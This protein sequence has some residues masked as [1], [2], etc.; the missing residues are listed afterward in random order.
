MRIDDIPLVSGGSPFGHLDELKRDRFALF[1]RLGRECGDIGAISAFGFPL[2][3]ANAPPLVHEVLVEKAKSFIK[4]PG[5]VGPLRPLAGEGLFTSEGELW[6]RQR[7]LMSPLFQHAQI[8]RYA[9][10]MVD[11]ARA[12]VLPLREGQVFD[13]ARETT[14]IA[15]RVAG[16][17]LFG[18]D[19]LD[20]ADELGAALT[21]ALHWIN[22]KSASPLLV[23]QIRLSELVTELGKHLPEPLQRRA[24]ELAQDMVVPLRLPGEET[25][26]LEHA[27][28][29]VDGQVER[30]IAERRAGGVAGQQDL[31]ARLLSVHDE[32]GERMSD[33]QL[34]DEIVTLFIAGHETTAT[35]L[36]WS[37]YLLSRHPEAYQRAKAEAEALGGRRARF[38]DLPRLSYCLQVFKEAMRLYPPIYIFGRKAIA[39]VEIGGYELPKGSIVIIAPWII[40]RRASIWPEPER[41]DP[42]RFEPAAEEARHKQ[43]FLPFSAGPRTCIGNHFAL[44]E[45]PLVL[46]TML[47]RVDLELAV[48]GPIQPEGTATLRP[49]GGMPMRVTAVRELAD[50]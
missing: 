20:E 11:C 45:G 32:Q 13:V 8:A 29:V 38:E 17:T 34:R 15:M 21:D 22:E 23:L 26:K 27:L 4:S 12:A 14:H 50:G 41:F 1:D 19:T 48:P 30:M 42:T 7:L 25:R 18:T 3:F 39:D 46:A 5:M 37:L 43:A 44:M 9:D 33:K 10:C 36:A 47:Q 2:I 35:A 24:A 16:K 31:L 28:A 49:L 40:H 6:R